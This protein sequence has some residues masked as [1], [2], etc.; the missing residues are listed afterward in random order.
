MNLAMISPALHREEYPGD[1]SSG[2]RSCTCWHYL[3]L[4]QAIHKWNLGIFFL[5]FKIISI[6]MLY[7]TTSCSL[8][9]PSTSTYQNVGVYNSVG[10]YSAA[11]NFI[12]NFHACF[13]F[14]SQIHVSRIK[15]RKS[16]HN[17]VGDE[18]TARWQ[19]IAII[20]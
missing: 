4:Q 1:F 7:I 6:Y 20:I 10:H 18:T 15:G 11:L 5:F 9:S 16:K 2:S 17:V 19:L 8:L 12:V 13:C 3:H 14:D